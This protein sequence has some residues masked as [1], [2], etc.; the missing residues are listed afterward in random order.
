MEHGCIVR[1]QMVERLVRI[2]PDGGVEIDAR[3]R[4]RVTALHP[5]IDYSEWYADLGNCAVV[6]LLLDS[7]A[8]INARDDWGILVAHKAILQLHI[9]VVGSGC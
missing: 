8:D 9:E 4:D 7:D 3:D 2:S 1:R 6:K 5:A